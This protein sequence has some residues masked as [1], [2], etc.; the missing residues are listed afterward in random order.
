MV[1]G[2]LSDKDEHHDNTDDGSRCDNRQKEDGP[3]NGGS[4]LDNTVKYVGQRQGCGQ[5]DGHAEQHVLEAV[6]HRVQKIF[7][8]KQLFKIV[9][10]DKDGIGC[11]ARPVQR[12]IEDTGDN[13]IS[14]EHDIQQCGR[15]HEH[16]APDTDFQLIPFLQIRF[17]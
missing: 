2:A 15:N 12:G 4:L 11:H 9:Q 13:G 8:L 1:D 5:L 7:I 16:P 17:Q 14:L 3:K 6:E 10:P